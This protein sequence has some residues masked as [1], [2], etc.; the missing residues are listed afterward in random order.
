MSR[1]LLVALLVTWSNVGPI[2]VSCLA[3]E[4]LRLAVANLRC[5]QRLNPLGIDELRPHLSWIVKSPVRGIQPVAFQVVVAESEHQL[6]Q[7]R[8]LVWDTGRVNTGDPTRAYYSGPRLVSRQ[9]LY[10]K[11]RI[12]AEDGSVSPWSDV[13]RWEMGLLQPSDWLGSWI[14]DG[15]RTPGNDELLYEDDPAP[16]FRLPFKLAKPVRRARLYVTGLGYYE[17]SLN[18]RRVGDALLDPAWTT[19]SKR[20][21]YCT[22][23]VTQELQ[24]GDNCLG[25]TLGNGWYNPLPLR[26]WGQLNIRDFMPLGR[27]GC[28]AQLEVEYDDGSRVTFATDETWRVAHG[29]ILRN[30]VYL[31]EVYDARREI[32]GWNEPDFD[33]SKWT[34]AALAVPPQGVLRAQAQ[35]AI[36]A[37]ATL[38]PIAR[39]EPRPGVYIFDFGENMAGW[40]RLK[41][42]GQEGTRVRLRFGELLYPDGTLNVM[43]TVCGQIKEPGIGGPGAPAV[44]EQADTYV[45]RGAE[46]GSRVESY[47]PRFTYHGFRYIEVTGYPGDPD[48][49]S[50]EAVRL[51]TDVDNA[52]EFSCSNELFNRIQKMCRATFPSNLVGVQTD[53]PGR[54]RFAYGDDIACACEAHLYNYDMATFYAKTVEDFADA[55][56]PNGALTLLS[57]WTGHAI[58]GFDPGGGSFANVERNGADAGSGPLSG[59][60]AHSLLLDKL[61]QFYGD[62]RLVDEQ[63]EVAR[64]SL[65][66]I[67]AQTDDNLIKVG[68]GDWSSV[69]A[70][71][72]AILDTAMYY[73]HATIIARLARVI[74][75]D[76]DAQQYEA[77]ANKIRSAFIENFVRPGGNAA[78]LGTQAARSCALYHGLVPEDQAPTVAASLVD[79]VLVEH[80]GHLTTGIFGTKYLLEALTSTGNVDVATAIVNQ[81]TYPGW[82]YMLERGATTLWEVWHFSDNVYSHNHSMFGTVSAWFFTA[83]GGIQPAEDAVGFDKILL[84]PQVPQGTTWVKASYKSVRGE[85]ASNWYIDG[86]TFHWDVTIPPTATAELVIPTQFSLDLRESDLPI[87]QAAGVARIDN[88]D[89]LPTYLLQSG[90]Y[91]FKSHASRPEKASAK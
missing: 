26:M 5:E 69:E 54:E 12:W 85:I 50:L 64:R 41:V 8:D 10:W 87:E 22:F 14:D 28:L 81:T 86:D 66:F 77:L 62:R 39:T 61:Y 65:E 17:A 82:G 24:S 79:D 58:G 31:G 2:T 29:P 36:K 73:Q 19:Y 33:D 75:R 45:L 34:K 4:P 37:T 51:N 71:D 91:H 27:P 63:Y 40:G 1:R 72:T 42:R 11:V 48:M 56:R 32:A 90:T 53:C 57:P 15:H 78:R 47:E 25:L 20:V 38:R 13:A 49:D 60:L 6:L 9:R 43:T 16:L 84:R 74:G 67:R 55:A 46:N 83:L 76:A 18:G 23:D 88:A 21:L 35:P 30:N 59:V 80:E 68:L 7:Q 89:A 70:T 3:A 44:A 52:G